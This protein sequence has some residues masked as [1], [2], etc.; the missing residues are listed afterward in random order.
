MVTAREQRRVSRDVNHDRAVKVSD[1]S[2]LEELLYEALRQLPDQERRRSFLE[3]VGIDRPE[4]RH[5]L[6]SLLEAGEG[7]NAFFALD[8]RNQPKVEDVLRELQADPASLGA[9]I[10]PDPDAAPKASLP[11]DLIGTVIGRY[12]ILEKIGEGG[13]GVVYLAEQ[14]KPVRRRVALKLIKLGMDTSEVVARFEAERQAL[15]LMEHPNIAKVLDGGATETG[16]LF[17]VME[18]VRGVRIT[19]YCDDH[20]LTTRE[21]IALVIQVAQAVQHA[22]Q[23]G[24][25][26]R[27]LKPSNI[28]VTIDDGRPVP[29]VIDFGIAK[30]VAGRLTDRTLFTGFEQLVGT[31]AYM[32]PEQAL[33]TSLDI[34]TRADLYS[35]GVLLYELLTGKTPFETQTLLAAGLHEMRRTILEMEPARPST[36]LSSLTPAE[37]TTTAQR[38]AIQA[39]KLVHLLQGDL[40]WIV[41]KC[42]E[43]D[44]TRRYE[45]ANGFAKD[46]QR[47]LDNEPVLA[48][49]PS[50]TYR[51]QKLIRRNRPVVIGALALLVSL[52]IGLGLSTWLYTRERIAH[53][54]ALREQQNAEQERKR[55]DQ[56]RSE[57]EH[58]L[59]RERVDDGWSAFERGSY[60][61]AMAAFTDALRL[62]PAPPSRAAAHRLRL[63]AIGPLQPKLLRLWQTGTEVTA[64]ALSPDG[65]HLALAGVEGGE[66]P[67]TRIFELE[68]GRP[69]SAP[70]AHGARINCIAFSPDSQSLVTGSHDRTARVWDA[71][72]GRPRTVPFPQAAPVTTVGFSPDSS[73]ILVGG[74]DVSTFATGQV[75][76]IDVKTQTQR[77]QEQEYGMNVRLALF[78]P[79]GRQIVRGCSSFLGML[80][81]L[82]RGEEWP[83]PECWCLLSGAFSASG[84]SFFAGGSFG[85]DGGDGGARWLDLST[86]SWRGPLLRHDGPVVSVDLSPDG[87]LAATASNDRTARVWRVDDGQRATLPLP[88]SSAVLLVRFSHNS[89]RVLTVSAD[90]TVRVWDAHDG[91]PLT[92]PMPHAGAV[93]LAAFSPDDQAIW[94]VS[95]D[96]SVC[97]WAAGT[98]LVPRLNLTHGSP[99]SN[100]IPGPNDTLVTADHSQVCVWDRQSGRL[101]SKS[102][103]VPG[104]DWTELHG[105]SGTRVWVNQSAAVSIFDVATGRTVHG[106]SAEPHTSFIGGQFCPDPSRGL[107]LP[108]GSAAVLEFDTNTGQ[109]T[110]RF[111][112]DAPLLATALRPDGRELLA[113]AAKSSA[114]VWDVGTAQLRQ[115]IHLSSVYSPPTLLFF[116]P[117]SSRLCLVDAENNLIVWKAAELKSTAPPVIYSHGVRTAQFSPDSRWLAAGNVDGAARIY[118]A[119]SGEVAVPALPHNGPI[120][121]LQFSPDSLALATG[122]EDSNARVWETLTGQPITPPLPQGASVVHVNFTADGRSL[123]TGCWDGRAHL[124]EVP[125]QSGPIA[126]L[127]AAYCSPSH[128]ANRALQWDPGA[129]FAQFVRVLRNR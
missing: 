116:S 26:H 10:R 108:K 59:A 65:S 104:Q 55:A 84:S 80:L 102:R 78:T 77:W 44:R 34:D 61:G 112:A 16:R 15:A 38:R 69:V 89:H 119:Q 97:A 60:W 1:L 117:D 92:L 9:A 32:S 54:R 67:A 52:W 99:V 56:L 33:T 31:P 53:G 73:R 36:R 123:L 125:S 126:D 46:L 98:Q 28:L 79:D 3:L 114:F 109:V 124:W 88:H 107:V 35:L 100:V 18:L 72:S 50:A 90:R 106:P 29:K 8:S 42:L 93:V 71:S 94:T 6:E 76:V 37:L 57:T 11:R 19:D 115:R 23:K 66:S 121:C 118:S 5:R 122:S 17:F 48:R 75:A 105:W 64:A 24:I 95:S 27:D 2:D 87:S 120:N 74:W 22:H 129:G 30:A 39:T 4:L 128:A 103:E 20:K 111:E 41:M 127:L 43:K 58:L 83:I 85:G 62:E 63:G 51:L 101:L 40:D 113:L 25:I 12:Q 7:A 81:D 14:D 86:F 96:G 68:S 45:T 110:R 47:Y 13:Y 21:R 70:M 91:R 82:E 49:P